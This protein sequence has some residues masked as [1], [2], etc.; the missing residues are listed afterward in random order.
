MAAA[1]GHSAE[2]R[3]HN[4][5]DVGQKYMKF[6]IEKGPFFGGGLMGSRLRS[7]CLAFAYRCRLAP[8]L[9]LPSPL[10][11]PLPL[12]R[13]TP[14]PL[15]SLPTGEFEQ[16]GALCPK[17]LKTNQS[18]WD[19]YV[20]MFLDLRQHRVIS[21]Y[22]PKE[23]PRLSPAVYEMVLHHFLQEENPQVFLKTIREW[24]PVIYNTNVIISAVSDRLKT[25]PD[26][27]VLQEALAELYVGCLR[28][29]EP[30]RTDDGPIALVFV[31]C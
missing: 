27:A 28:S 5:L 18:L 20:H 13:P 31:G 12:P 8:I 6:L 7:H 25:D 21:K 11:L 30:A 17:V 16:A 15:R 3:V 4:L 23:N 14:H 9:T 2:L 10:A 19:H 24:P 22:I 29:R 26:N 1:E